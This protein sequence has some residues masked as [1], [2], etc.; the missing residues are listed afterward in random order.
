[1]CR[2]ALGWDRCD[3]RPVTRYSPPCV[4]W[5]RELCS[6][7]SAPSPQAAATQNHRMTQGSARGPDPQL[8][9]I[10]PLQPQCPGLRASE[11]LGWTCCWPLW[12]RV[13]G[14]PHSG[15]R[16]VPVSWPA[17]LIWRTQASWALSPRTLG[18]K[19]SG[20]PSHGPAFPFRTVSAQRCLLSCDVSSS[21][22]RPCFSWC[23]SCWL[24]LPR[25]AGYH[26]GLET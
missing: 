13:G 25:G 14:R 7:I 15:G 24:Q 9:S 6:P 23:L 4:W 20:R 5:P 3:S 18:L 2:G 10:P 26:P 21:I 17:S 19:G 12:T 22:S 16:C 8:L 1:M 11:H